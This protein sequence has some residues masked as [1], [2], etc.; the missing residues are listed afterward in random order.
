MSWDPGSQILTKGGIFS[1]LGSDS[2]MEV[3]GWKQVMGSGTGVLSTIRA[4]G[5]VR[6]ET[7][8]SQRDT[9]Q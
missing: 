1:Q 7:H 9:Q 4:Y 5:H 2:E 3:L 6:D 8:I